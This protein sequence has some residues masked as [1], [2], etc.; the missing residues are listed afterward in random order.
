M[1][2]FILAFVI[3]IIFYVFHF[4][5][6]VSKYPKGPLPLPFIGNIH[7]FPPDNVQK[8]FDVL[9]KTYGPCFTIWIPFPAIVLT[10]YEHIKDAFVNQ[11]D[12]FTYRAHRSPETLL[13]VHDH[14]G[15]LASD[16]DHWRLQ[17]RTSLKI[18][19][20]FGLGRNLM[21]EQ[22]IRSVHEMLIQLENINDKKNVDVFWPIQLCVG[23]VIN[24]T[25]F[26]FHYKYEDSEKF[27]TFV[28]IVDKHLRHL[29]GKMPLLVSAFPWLKHV[30]IV[31]DIG[32]H[33][34]KNNISSYHTFIEEEVAT[35]VKKYDGESEP[36]NFVHA[37]MQ[38]MKQTGNPGLDITNL[39]AT[40]LDF[41]LA[42]METTSN[43]LRWHL[44]FMMKYPEVQDKVRKEIL[45]NVGT[46]RLPSMSDKPNM[47][48]T[49]AVIHE[50]QRC[51]NMIPFLGSHQC[52]EETEIHGNRVPAG[53][54]V[55]AQL[56]S[57]MR[58]DTVFEDPE[59]FNPSRYL[60]SDGKTFDK[61]VLEKT[62]P[63]SIGKRNCVGEGLARME[64]F[65]IFSALI[66]KY[67]FVATS[68]IDLTPDWGV[69]LTAKP[70]TCNIIPQF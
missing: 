26:G 57:V 55:F 2:V 4:Y 24:E 27:K 20:D 10:D 16:G 39:C 33:N 12:T 1:S 45:D 31:G 46:A 37:Y 41:W 5:W 63:F 48:Y 66:Q 34:I 35:Q 19:R 30:P 40:V 69:V 18:L 70:Y 62:I 61:A 68:N 14:T 51:S 21:E 3:F 29:Q 36:E 15:I 54:L 25:L 28:K 47:P 22:V 17:R 64:L 44:A 38:Q 43:S 42:G 59:T 56:W 52:K 49:Q 6:K 8:Y 58:N 65:L 11:G 53:S 67:E 13:P 60:Q 7:Q 23:N 9:S 50:V 32:Y